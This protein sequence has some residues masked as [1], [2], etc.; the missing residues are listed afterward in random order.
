MAPS[1]GFLLPQPSVGPP[2]NGSS[3]GMRKWGARRRSSALPS[4]DPAARRNGAPR[5]GPHSLPGT[6]WP[7][8]PCPPLRMGLAACP[9]PGPACLPAPQPLPQMFPGPRLSLPDPGHSPHRR[10]V[11]VGM[12]S[13]CRWASPAEE[14]APR[15]GERVS[16]CVWPLTLARRPALWPSPATLPIQERAWSCALSTPASLQAPWLSHLGSHACPWSS[17]LSFSRT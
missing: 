5:S 3:G 13:Q 10:G 14:D 7:E 8:G 1:W 4:G 15:P 12:L 2:V 11:G 17:A 6:A 9:P 16:P